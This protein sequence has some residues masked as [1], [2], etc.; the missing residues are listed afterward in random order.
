MVTFV[1]LH[2]WL[3]KISQRSQTI[4]TRTRWTL[5][6]LLKYFCTNRTQEC[7]VHLPCCC[8]Q[9][10]IITCLYFFAKSQSKFKPVNLSHFKYIYMSSV[11]L[12]TF[13]ETWCLSWQLLFSI[14]RLKVFRTLVLSSTAYLKTFSDKHVWKKCKRE[15]I[16]VIAHGQPWTCSHP[17]YIRMLTGIYNWSFV[18][19][20]SIKGNW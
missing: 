9:I 13:K 6:F 10:T 17:I 14:S 18:I 19:T 5:K 15:K 16:F 11:F 3:P 1:L 20:L 7:L 12:Q 4:T 2:V 8:D